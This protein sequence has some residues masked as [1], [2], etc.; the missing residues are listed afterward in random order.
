MATIYKKMKAIIKTEDGIKLSELEVP[1]LKA[2]NSILI[3]V[4]IAGLCRTDLYTAQNKIP[5][6]LGRIL[7][8]EFSGIVV[9]CS[10]DVTHIKIGDKVGIMPFATHNHQQTMMG[11]DLN[12]GYA[13]YVQVP[14]DQA[15]VIP[16]NISLQ[17]AAFL[18]PIAASLAITKAPINRN[19]QGLI[20]GNNRIAELTLRILHC[21]NF[22]HIDSC[23]E[24]NLAKLSCNYDFVIE[25]IHTED[26]FIHMINLVKI[27]GIILLK[28]RPF[29]SIPLPIATIV[30]K[31][32]QLFGVNYGDFQE[33]IDLL[34][35]GTL[36][37]N[38]LFGEIYSFEDAVAILTAPKAISEDKKIFFTPHVA[39]PVYSSSCNNEHSPNWSQDFF[40]E[41]F[42]VFLKRD[43]PTQL[44]NEIDFIIQ[45]LHLKKNE[46]VLD[47]CCGFGALSLP[48]AKKGIHVIGVDQSKSYIKQASQQAFKENLPC[49]FYHDDA[50]TFVCPQQV[51]AAFNWYT[52]F[53]YNESD[54]INLKMLENVY[55]NL[56][57]GGRY[58]LDYY[59]AAYILQNFNPF[60]IIE[61]TLPQG[62]L[63]IHKNCDFDLVRGMLTSSWQYILP[64][65]RRKTL[66]GESR[67][68][69]AR[70][71]LTLFQTCGFKDIHF[72]GDVFNN[73]L[74]KDSKRCIVLATK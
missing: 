32:L 29:V 28:S 48:L 38:D 73:E 66:K 46:F 3:Q 26:A 37:I 67:I 16:E 6:P 74:T 72:F 25:T 57:P 31:E 43:N 14:A 13:E 64:D 52:S 27:G 1:S 68:Y 33:G 59:N 23:C 24:S 34:A 49:Q 63:I 71:F 9:E 61:K 30:K 17:A 12:G 44:S 7:G 47:Q 18:E 58:L 42:G 10:Q 40:D 15:Y 20:V 11:I 21:K 54:M 53:G 70:D 36:K 56:K 2:E 19:Q 55:H 45:T 41:N 65:G 39:K 8:H 69:F 51:D 35:S 50:L 5:V 62:Q 22:T 60:Q 4:A